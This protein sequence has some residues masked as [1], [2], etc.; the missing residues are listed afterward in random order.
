MSAYDYYF[1]YL[2][3]YYTLIDPVRLSYNFCHNLGNLYDLT[4]EAIR[5][6]LDFDNVWYTKKYWERMGYIS[7]GIIQSW[8][9]EPKDYAMIKDVKDLYNRPA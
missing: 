8:L 6:S 4:E 7:G 9:E 1:A 2:A 5:R 3:Y